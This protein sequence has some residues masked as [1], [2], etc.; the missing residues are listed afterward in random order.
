MK[1]IPFSLT[2]AAL[3]FLAGCGDNAVDS[4]AIDRETKA[5]ESAAVQAMDTKE[6]VAHI[7]GLAREMTLV[8]QSKQYAEMHH[9]EIALTKALI[10][11]EGQLSPE[12]APTLKPIIETLKII[13]AKIHGV[14]HDRN[15]SMAA[16]LDKTL[17]DYAARLQR[18]LERA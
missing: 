17:T 5:Y 1:S 11:L 9:L 13:A 8:T 3:F 4:H 6:L 10:A 16:T 15:Q 14:G 2:I 7:Q 18:A 12:D